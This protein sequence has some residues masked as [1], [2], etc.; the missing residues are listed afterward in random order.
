MI[1]SCS[2]THCTGKSTFIDAFVQ[3]WPMY[4]KAP[5][6]RQFVKDNNIQIND[7]ATFEDQKKILLFLIDVVEKC[8]AD[9]NNNHYILDR[10]S[11][12]VLAYS[13]W[14]YLNDRMTF[15]QLDEI[16]KL[17]FISLSYYDIIFLFT[18]R[19]NNIPFIT[20]EMRTNADP[21]YQQGVNSL[22]MEF[23]SSYIRRDQKIFPL[24]NS[25]ALIEMEAFTL[26]DRLIFAE[27]YISPTGEAYEVDEKQFQQNII[28]FAEAQK[29][30]LEQEQLKA[31]KQS[32]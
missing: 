20:D 14:M 26:V 15:K 32:Y 31:L 30:A 3:K 23:L 18:L 28:T 24:E 7:K 22:F 4:K 29:E 12:D 6:Y 11:L 5:T 16:R 27:Q 9:K 19:Y 13:A 1:I 10:G 8:R 25:P 2:G 21:S 17:T